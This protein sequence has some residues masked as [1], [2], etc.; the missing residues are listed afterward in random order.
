MKMHIGVDAA[1]GLTHT[2]AGTAANVSDLAMAGG[3][4]QDDDQVVFADAGYV[5]AAKRPENVGK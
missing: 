5:G 4:L 3:L 2:A 1:F